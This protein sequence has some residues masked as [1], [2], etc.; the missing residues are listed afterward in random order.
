[1]ARL[2][3]L[4]AGLAGTIA[5]AELLPARPGSGIRATLVLLPVAAALFALLHRELSA[6]APRGAEPVVGVAWLLFALHE[7]SVGLPWSGRLLAA[8]WALLVAW[9]AA[10]LL[11]DLRRQLAP[12]RLKRKLWLFALLPFT[13]G[14]AL[15]P[16]IAAADEPDGDEPY[17]LLLTESLASDGD[18][19]LADE[20]GEAVSR[21]FGSRAIA[22]QPGDPTDA[23]GAIRSRH[24]SL[25]VPYLVPFWVAGGLFGARLGMV[26]LWAL[27][28]MRL[29]R[30]LLAAG[31]TPRGA[32][33]GWAIATF[34]P[35]ALLFATQ[36]WTEM[37]AALAAT[38]ALELTLARL[39]RRESTRRGE[40]LVLGAALAVLPLLKLRFALIAAPLALVALL[41]GRVR[42][43]ARAVVTALV[44]AALAL[45]LLRNRASLGKAIGLHSWHDLDLL[46]LPFATY[47][48]RL[49]GLFFDLAFGL[50]AAA[51]IWLLALAGF[52]RLAARRRTLL[53][54]LAVGLPYLVITAR[55]QF[56]FGGWSPP[57]R[58]GVVLLPLLAVALGAAFERP[59]SR[60]GAVWRA[61]LG[62]ATLVVTLAFVVEPGW[63]TSFA[64]G[65]SRLLDLVSR[66]F[67]ADFARFAPSALRPRLATWL[68]PAALV[69]LAYLGE[70]GRRRALFAAPAWAAALL[71]AVVA[72]VTAAAHRLPTRSVEI[73]D[74]WIAKRGGEP[75]PSLWTYDRPLYSGGWT[76]GE[77]A[78]VALA[79]VTGGATV[80]LAVR[81]RT[82][83]ERP[84]IVEISAGDQV[85]LAREV[86]TG[87]VWDTV[88]LAPIRWE[89]GAI[90][91]LS[92]R[93]PPSTPADATLLV[94][95]I[96]FDWR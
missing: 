64:D 27:F 53:V 55:Q 81:L 26:V 60:R 19:D 4:L 5:A 11:P 87:G 16:W 66:P 72:G 21:R 90:L 52:R 38:V 32:F 75:Y 61:A 48:L 54:L 14:L 34:S 35:P 24:E 15:L 22:P 73:E 56:W 44:A 76:L 65:R 20:Y 82:E 6:R 68:L 96:D 57:F 3:P 47:L 94:D 74:P 78:S 51:P 29:L 31:L 10:Q 49:D 17:Y 43:R 62:L 2:A 95:R 86:A 33:R 39:G 28:S 7:E 25:L 9:R 93:R 58:Y 85:R 79:P 1:M 80:T 37:A 67:A 92:A 41:S 91:E 23:T 46:E 42:L 59:A 30:L 83:L 70:R 69:G 77:S 50:F 89:A 36:I 84:M 63:A 71:L 12:S 18:F 40:L 88:E 13:V 45:V 8:S